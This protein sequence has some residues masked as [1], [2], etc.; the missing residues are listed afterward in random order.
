MECSESEHDDEEEEYEYAYSSD[1]DDMEDDEEGD[2]AVADERKMTMEKHPSFRAGG[3]G[4]QSSLSFLYYNRF[5]LISLHHSKTSIQTNASQSTGTSTP[6]SSAPSKSGIRMMQ[7]EDLR[8]EMMSRCKD[9]CEVLGISQSTA[10]VLLSAFCW[11]K[12]TLL[13]QYMTNAEQIL[14]KAGVYHRA[15][16]ETQP[17]QSPSHAKSKSNDSSTCF[18]CFEDSVDQMLAMPCGHAFCTDCWRLFCENAVQEG[19]SCVQTTCPDATCPEVV[20]EQEM[21]AALGSSDPALSKYQQYQLRSFVESNPLTRWCP[22]PGCERIAVAL[23]SAA[24]ERDGRIAQCDACSVPPLKFCVLCGAEPHAPASC[25]FVTQW[26]E[27]CRNES[28]TAN[29]ILA[30]TKSCP[31]CHCRI[32]KNQGCNHMTCQ[33]CRHEFCWICMGDWKEHGS[34]TGGYYKCNKF[35]DTAGNSDDPVG[36]AQ[37]ELDRYLHFYSR[38]HAHAEA[39]RFARQQRHGIDVQD[40]QIAAQEQLVECRRVLKFTYVFAYYTYTPVNG[41]TKPAAAATSGPVSH[42]E[43]FEHHQE[44]LERFTESL[45]ELTERPAE[46]QDRT[47]LVNQTRVVDRFLKNILKYVE[48]GMEDVV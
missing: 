5:M 48:D 10:M 14:K 2:Y 12:E 1:E 13:E 27:K 31:K 33:K 32:E 34:N 11:S 42:R 26:A 9:V 44:M 29:W 16:Q 18:I 24:L 45:H 6:M 38:Y 40:Y 7:A 36:Q 37:R 41:D 35:D 20:T 15:T 47:E 19:P 3:G 39:Q 28:E 43:R 21:R 25:Q 4:K 30:N 22:G 8:P 17:P 46:N 23:S